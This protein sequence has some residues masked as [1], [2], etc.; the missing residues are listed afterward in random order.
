MLA[1]PLLVSALLVALT[2][3]VQIAGLAVLI[4]VMRKRGGP[5][6]SVAH[7]LQQLGVILL[8]VLGVFVMHA[9]QIWLFAIVYLMLGEF[10]TFEAALY[11]STSSFTTVGYGEVVI[12]SRWRIVAAI[13]SA[14]GFLVLGWSTVFLISVLFRLRSVEMAWLEGR[15]EPDRFIPDLPAAQDEGRGGKDGGKPET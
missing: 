12:E 4:W 8:V 7:V 14:A 1:A 10:E 2:V 13:E 11:F 9:V 15:L 3:I 6:A 5:M